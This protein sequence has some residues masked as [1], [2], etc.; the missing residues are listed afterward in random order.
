MKGEVSQTVRL[1]L[2]DLRAEDA[3]DVAWMLS[4]DE[5][6]RACRFLDPGYGALFMVRRGLLRSELGEWLGVSPADIEFG[7]GRMGKPFAIGHDDVRFNVGH[8]DTLTLVAISD[9]EV[10]V[11]IETLDAIVDVEGIASRVFSKREGSWLSS[12]P[13]RHRTQAV[14]TT[15]ARKEAAAKAHGDGLGLDLTTIETVQGS[16][17]RSAKVRTAG[18]T[19]FLWDVETPD[20]HAAAIATPSQDVDIDYRIRLDD[21]IHDARPRLAPAT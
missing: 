6:D 12:L 16:R 11:D 8:A 19:W 1:L 13:P 10:G 2:A 5:I 9:R 20:D 4:Q 17:V 14:L 7:Q 15:W 21:E 18:S 3:L